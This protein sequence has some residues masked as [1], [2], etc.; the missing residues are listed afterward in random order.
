LKPARNG[1]REYREIPVIGLISSG[2]AVLVNHRG[3]SVP[4]P[5][6][7]LAKTRAVEEGGHMTGYEAMSTT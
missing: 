3:R 2:L 5:G 4:G 7:A 6:G 1:A